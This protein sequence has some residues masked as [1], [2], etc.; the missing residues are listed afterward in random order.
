MTKQNK[1]ND[2]KEQARVQIVID[3]SGFILG[4][5]ASYA[6][7]QSMLGKKVIIVNC[8]KAL[9][10]GRRRMIISE[11]SAARRRGGTSLNGPHFPKHSD[12]LVKRTVRGML[13][14]TQ[15][16][17]LDAL[18]RIICY[19]D[20][21]KE[22]ESSKKISSSREIKTKTISIGDLSSEL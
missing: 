10:T 1:T 15:Q 2:N 5:L 3:A 22:Y 13:S 8:D 9:V 20:V 16:R 21:P 19:N 11:Y 14:Y 4:R 17:G 7:K 12:R 6:A 18:K